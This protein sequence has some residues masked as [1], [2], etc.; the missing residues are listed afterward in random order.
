MLFTF[1]K[2][3]LGKF[4]SVSDDLFT[5]LTKVRNFQR[6]QMV[7]RHNNPPYS[8][9]WRIARFRNS[10]PDQSSLDQAKKGGAENIII[11]SEAQK[12]KLTK[13]MILDLEV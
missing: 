3:G 8:R 13:G 6:R 1:E 12:V 4:Y 2:S 9:L 5:V 10:L 11:D 7:F